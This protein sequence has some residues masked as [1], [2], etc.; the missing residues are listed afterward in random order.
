MTIYQSTHVTVFGFGPAFNRQIVTVA[1]Q[2]NEAGQFRLIEIAGENK[3]RL[4]YPSEEPKE[5][6]YFCGVFNLIA[7]KGHKEWKS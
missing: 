5:R 6:A 3:G 1:A 7:H 2:W 4:F